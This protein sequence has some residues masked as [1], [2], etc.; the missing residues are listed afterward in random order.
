[1]QSLD[2]VVSTDTSVAHLSAAAGV[3]T[4]VALPL[5]A[6]YRWLLGPTQ[7]GAP[8][9]SRWEERT[10]YYDNMKLFRQREHGQWGSVFD[11][12][13]NKLTK[14]AA[15]RVERGEGENRNQNQHSNLEL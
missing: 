15:E 11:R 9:D 4:W 5:K 12:I 10:P 14:K 1:M 6:D 7:Q 3:E 2:L 8:A 13:K